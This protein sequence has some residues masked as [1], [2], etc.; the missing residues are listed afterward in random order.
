MEII[1]KVVGIGNSDGIILDKIIM[2]N[3]NVRRG[4]Y[5]DIS[6][7]CKVKMG[8]SAEVS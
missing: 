4:D 8:E 3:L 7:I 1:K 2:E 6:N 5:I